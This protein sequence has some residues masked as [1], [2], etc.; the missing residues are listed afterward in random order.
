MI[1]ILLFLSILVLLKPALVH[2]F[3]YQFV[4]E[5]NTVDLNFTKVKIPENPQVELSK[6]ND[7]L[8]FDYKLESE[9]NLPT[10]IPLF[11][12]VFNQEVIFSADASLLDEKY[13]TT[14][15][16]MK[17]FQAYLGQMPVF[18]KNN[19]I[20]DFKLEIANVSFIDQVTEN[21]SLV[22]INDLNIIREKEGFLTVIFSLQEEIKNPHLYQLFCLNEKQEIVNSTQLIQRDNFLWPDY[23]FANLVV[24]QKNELIFH[25]E[26]F[27]CSGEL[28]VTADSS[29]KSDKTSIIG[30]E[31]L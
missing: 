15:V 19:V 17:N 25:L 21:E 28:Y 8:S 26:K 1:L 16:G 22:E 5:N 7:V 31:N 9:E 27:N 11:I 29:S 20:E 18:Y 10:D 4:L 30:I 2:G 13:H 14:E 23:F 6:S 3:T 12:V 24:N